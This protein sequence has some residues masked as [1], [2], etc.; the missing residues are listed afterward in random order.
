MS[1]RRDDEHFFH[2]QTVS[3]WRSDHF[4]PLS[5]RPAYWSG[6]VVVQL[7]GTLELE[8]TECSATTR[9]E[10]GSKTIETFLSFYTLCWAMKRSG[11]KERDGHCYSLF[12]N[13]AATP[14]ACLDSDI[15]VSMFMTV[16]ISDSPHVSAGL[17][18][19][20][21]HR[22]LQITCHSSKTHW[23][24]HSGAWITALVPA[25]AMHRRAATAKP[26]P[27]SLEKSSEDGL[28]LLL[29]DMWRPHIELPPEVL[30]DCKGEGGTRLKP[31]AESN[32]SHEGG[33]SQS[34]LTSNCVTCW[35]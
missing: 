18:K 7:L 9:S 21:D 14:Q 23:R 34:I 6:L 15:H 16:H 5:L 24:F 35:D 8:P 25:G 30:T 4:R 26:T 2:I 31:S 29:V 33:E 13:R 19:Q 28:I 32:E 3:A 1:C 12:V 27:E 11:Q 22:V 17:W 20:T 10:V